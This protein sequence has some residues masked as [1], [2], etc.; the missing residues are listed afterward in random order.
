MPLV[1]A[2][3]GPLVSAAD[4]DD[5]AHELASALVRS[6]G[7]DLVVPEPVVVEV[8]WL[9]RSLLGHRPA[10]VFL[11]VLVAGR[12]RRAALTAEQFARAVEIDRMYADLSLGV[13]DASVMALAEAERAP[14]LTFD[15]THFRATTDRDGRPWRLVIEEDVV[16]QEMR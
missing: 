4:R 16:A 5:R 1:V 3:T 14:I 8:D 15:F 10:R 9:L 12:P 6:A 2:D 7:T 11:A 13:P